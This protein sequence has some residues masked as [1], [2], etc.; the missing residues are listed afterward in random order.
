MSC[1]ADS[2]RSACEIEKLAEAD[3]LP[4]MEAKWP[5]CIF[6][7]TRHHRIV[8]KV[9]GDY[10]ASQ[11]GKARYIEI[12]AEKENIWGNVFIETWSNKSRRTL[13][14]FHACQADWLWYYFLASRE[15]YIWQM[16]HLRQWAR[17]LAENGQPRLFT[18]P[19]KQQ[20][21]YEQLNDTW[22][23]PVPM[24]VL[25]IAL[26]SFRGPF[27]VPPTGIGASGT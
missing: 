9:C 25:K 16:V 15:L 18:Y 22:G 20:R 26:P 10:L 11:K 7:P 24:S 2:Y 27:F 17:S 8:Q 23:H 21:R 12:K 1:S 3:L 5:Q 19:E 13:G 6:Y 4:Y 14:W